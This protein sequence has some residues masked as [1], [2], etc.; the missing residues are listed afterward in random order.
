MKNQNITLT[1]ITSET[2]YQIPLAP[3]GTTSAPLVVNVEVKERSRFEHLQDYAY[4]KLRDPLLT[5]TLTS[6]F[7]LA[8][9]VV[10]IKKK[11]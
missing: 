11:R 9:I 2:V 6:V 7:W 8:I 3:V 10:F 5:A 4:N 1:P